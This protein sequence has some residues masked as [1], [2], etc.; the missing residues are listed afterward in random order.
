MNS[1]DDRGYRSALYQLIDSDTHWAL[2]TIPL[3]AMRN[4]LRILPAVAWDGHINFWMSESNDNRVEH[5]AAVI[6]VDAIFQL[7]QKGNSDPFVHGEFK[8]EEPVVR[9]AH[10]SIRTVRRAIEFMERF[11]SPE[12][13]TT[14]FSV[15]HSMV[16]ALLSIT[17]VY[18]GELGSLGSA[19][20]AA[21]AV[22]ESMGGIAAVRSD[23]KAKSDIHAALEHDIDRAI[24]FTSKNIVEFSI[25]PIWQEIPEWYVESVNKLIDVADSLERSKGQERE[26][27]IIEFGIRYLKEQA[28][29]VEPGKSQINSAGSRRQLP[30]ATSNEDHLNRQPLISALAAVLAHKSNSEHQTIGLLGD[31]GVG[32]STWL[33]LLKKELLAEH[34]EQAYLFGEFNAWAYE[35]TDNLQAGIAQEV[36]KALSSPA[37]RLED[38]GH[39]LADQIKESKFAFSKRWLGWKYDR[40]ILTA[41]FAVQLNGGELLKLAFLLMLALCPLVFSIPEL[42]SEYLASKAATQSQALY[43]GAGVVGNALWF[44]GFGVYFVK[45]FPKLF[46]NP[47]AKEM[48]TYLRLPDYAKHLGTVPVMRK[49]IETLCN[50][51]LKSSS[52]KPTRLL[53]VVDDLDRCGHDGIVKV[54]EAVR[55]VLDIKNVTVIIAVDQH[56]ALA[57]LAL[58]YEEVAKHHKL[59]NPN[60]IAR[61][62]LAKVIH[63]PIILANPM[64]ADIE[65][66]LKRLWLASTSKEDH[67]IVEKEQLDYVQQMVAVREKL[68]SE[69]AVASSSKGN[70][71]MQSVNEPSLRTADGAQFI[72]N[73]ALPARDPKELVYSSV[74]QNDIERP[75]VATLSAAQ[76][77]AFIFWLNYFALTNPRQ[78]KR[79]NNTYNLLLNCYND[80][81]RLPILTDLPEPMPKTL[82]PMMM[83]LITM[84]YLNSMGDW[85]LR[86]ALRSQLFIHSVDGKDAELNVTPLTKEFISA[87]HLLLSEHDG[88]VEKVRPFVLPAIEM[89]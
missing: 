29:I 89:R 50:I 36:I 74:N 25:Y 7:L 59:K 43:R 30:E 47:L 78:V 75:E 70:S 18:N 69:R 61:D 63:L 5:L 22:I 65:S 32:K 83:A 84:E 73:D 10:N 19:K 85:D 15:S 38:I 66:Y 51:R 40:A 2:Q 64:G 37:T 57:A 77:R 60:A 26:W 49:N 67:E 71:E 31:W 88:L 80:V 55:L 13:F 41:K 52:E 72:N 35:H 33:R 76:R 14:G 12:S 11:S 48:L 86:N 79:L 23:Q 34:K 28:G 45:E 4:A 54:F 24:N 1:S 87:F 42:I 53:F 17:R 9:M 46:A 68:E 8:G 20:Y 21:Q 44:L 27:Q 58:H 82:F 6:S 62:Y 39:A 3:I 56:I 16:G 81:D